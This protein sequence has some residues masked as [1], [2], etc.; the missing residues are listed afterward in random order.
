MPSPATIFV[1]L[2]RFS[3]FQEQYAKAKEIQCEI[4]AAETQDVADTPR[5]G[6]MVKTFSDGSQE[7][8]EGDML[9]RSRLILV[10]CDNPVS[11]RLRASTDHLAR[12]PLLP[13]C[14]PRIT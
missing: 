8:T 13:P 7:I 11:Q 6:R 3:D 14:L 1:W 9:D 12:A 4:L 5:V 2:N 10:L